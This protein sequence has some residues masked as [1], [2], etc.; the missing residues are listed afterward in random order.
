MCTGLR[1]RII[2][3]SLAAPV[4]P[5]SAASSLLVDRSADTLLSLR[6]KIWEFLSFQISQTV[7][8]SMEHTP[9][10][11]VPGRFPIVNHQS[12]TIYEVDQDVSCSC[13]RDSQLAMAP[14]C[15]SKLGI[16]QWSSARSQA[17]TYIGD[18]RGCAATHEFAI[19]PMSIPDFEWLARQRACTSKVPRVPR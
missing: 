12:L 2:S 1:G 18:T 19:Y 8:R 4:V 11:G 15:F 10:L 7:R 3:L 6:W 14:R 16:Q 13:S 5:Q 9:F 17:Y